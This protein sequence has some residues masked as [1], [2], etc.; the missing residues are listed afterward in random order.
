M[1]MPERELHE[2]T[3]LSASITDDDRIRHVP[4]PDLL[5]R[6]L[7][8]VDLDGSQSNKTDRRHLV[9]ASIAAAM[10]LV[11]G[12][13]L[14]TSGDPSETFV[15]EATNVDLP[16]VFEGTATATLTSGDTWTLSIDVAGTLP[17]SE[18]IEV[19]LIKPDLSDMVSLGTIAAGQTEWTWPAGYP[20]TEY[21]LVD[22]SIEPNDG[23]TTH[24]G[25]SI[26]RGELHSV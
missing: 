21:T 22:L 3:E 5:G 25:R 10:V 24:S 12:F 1:N 26:L 9:L 19:W 15:A 2:W 4:P 17:A 18:P 11:I 8:A 7:D 20:P 13:S 16:E 6:I 14:F 23:D